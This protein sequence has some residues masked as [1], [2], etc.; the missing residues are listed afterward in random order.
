MIVLAAGS[1]MHF[2]L[3]FVLLFILAV[4]IGQAIDSSAA[5]VG[6]I[7]PCVPKSE[8]AATC[9]KSD[10]ASPAAKSGLRTGDKIIALAGKPV[11]NWDQLG[12]AIRAQ[13]AGT[14]VTVTV[15]RDG[16]RLTLHPSLATIHG[17]KGSYL[18]ISP[19]VV[20]QTVGPISAVRY[21]G[22]DVRPGRDRLGV[23]PG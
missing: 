16:H 9:V 4:G 7:D 1:F 6:A 22:S 19:V 13:P 18:G 3:A 23:G 8:T 12:K 15:L 14:P 17:R 11:H 20:Y 10:P 5:T 2:V 21:A